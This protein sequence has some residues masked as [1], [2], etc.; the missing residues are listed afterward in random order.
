[1]TRRL[2]GATLALLA[3]NVPPATATMPGANGRLVVQREVGKQF[4]LFTINPDGSGERV[5]RRSPQTIEAEPAWSPDGRRLAFGSGPADEFVGEIVTTNPQGGGART[6]TGFGSFSGSPAWA[7]DGHRLAFFTLKDFED[8]DGLPPAEL[9]TIG[10]NGKRVRR[11]THDRQ[12][13][14]DPFYSPDGKHLVFAQWRAVKGREGTFDIALKIS[15]TDGTRVR[16]LTSISAKRDTLNASWSPDG[17]RLAFE[18]AGPRPHGRKGGRQS[19]LAVIRANGKGERR[20]TRTRAIETN[21]VWS[22]DGKQIAF[23]SDRHVADASGEQNNSASSS[24]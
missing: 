16:P 4:D 18:I 22:P 17:K 6:L 1:M 12:I 23:T 7:P 13:Q 9:Y 21:P 2:A 20:L 19:D 11:L 24:T 15:R 8:F 3:L 10:A 14:T 5:V